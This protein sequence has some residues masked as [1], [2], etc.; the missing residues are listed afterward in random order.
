VLQ[1][2]YSQYSYHGRQSMIFAPMKCIIRV[3]EQVT[4]QWQL[5]NE[6]HAEGRETGRCVESQRSTESTQSHLGWGR[7]KVDYSTHSC[8]NLDMN[9]IEYVNMYI[10]PLH[11]LSLELPHVFR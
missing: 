8:I 7:K 5:R 3:D 10:L 6:Q 1:V 4:S 2:F 11:Y 9:Y